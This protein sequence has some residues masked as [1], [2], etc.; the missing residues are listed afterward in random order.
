M[1]I[2]TAIISFFFFTGA[3]A[4]GLRER[5]D[6]RNLQ[7]GQGK[8]HSNDYYWTLAAMVLEFDG[9]CDLY[10]SY[11]YCYKQ[12]LTAELHG[13]GRLQGITAKYLQVCNAFHGCTTYTF[14]ESLNT[15]QI[16]KAAF[17]SL[18][19]FDT[20]DYRE[21][22]YALF[23][24]Y[25]SRC[26]LTRYGS[27]ATVTKCSIGGSNSILTGIGSGPTLKSLKRC[28]ILGR[29]S[30]NCSTYNFDSRTDTRSI[31]KDAFPEILNF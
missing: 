24:F 21:G 29:G 4:A 16:I 11:A 18:D 6:S 15:N 10:D 22:L 27:A 2:I 3:N 30:T 14:G 28:S 13:D 17:P 26:N 8:F 25:G 19:K 1:Y 23:L 7:Q 31:L 5:P 20:L 9:S 12:G